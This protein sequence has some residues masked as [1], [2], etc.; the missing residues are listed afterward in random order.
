VSDGTNSISGG[1]TVSAHI[2][3]PSLLEKVYTFMYY[4]IVTP[5]E[6][7][8]VFSMNLPA[9]PHGRCWCKPLL[10]FNQY[11]MNVVRHLYEFNPH[12]TT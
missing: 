10:V 5:T 1:H 6:Y 2:R 12:S 7:Q 8:I 9:K 4:M 3:A 11:V